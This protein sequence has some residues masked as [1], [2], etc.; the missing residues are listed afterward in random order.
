MGP[1]KV[2][3]SKPTDA[4]GE[5]TSS[6]TA[7]PTSSPTES[8]SPRTI[9]REVIHGENCVAEPGVLE[10]IENCNEE[11]CPVCRDCIKVCHWGHWEDWSACTKCGGQMKRTRQMHSHS[12][13]HHIGHSAE[14][15]PNR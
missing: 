4:P 11:P 1:T 13:E 2:P 15:H 7:P 9:S 3:T 6:P 10:R 12:M 8:P 14:D 5:P